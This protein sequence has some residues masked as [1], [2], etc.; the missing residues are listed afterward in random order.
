MKTSIPQIFEEVE[1]AGSKE[2]KI[3][4]LRAYDHPIL[5]GM[6]QINFD[7]NLI[8]QMTTLKISSNSH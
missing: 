6:L 2:A 7:P 8:K 3:K 5:K 4:T 1:K